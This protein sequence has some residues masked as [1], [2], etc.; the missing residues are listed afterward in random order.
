[1]SSFVLVLHGH[2]PWVVH[3]GR[4][5][6][7]EEWLHEAVAET[8]LPLLSALGRLDGA[9]API[10]VGLTPVLLEQLA[11][12]RFQDAFVRWLQSRRERALRDQREFEGWGDQHLAS[13]AGRHVRSLEATGRHFEALGRDLCGAFAALWQRGRVEIMGSAATHA[14]L[15]LLREDDS[16]RRQI[17]QG[18]ATSERLLGR[19]PTGF[20]MP[21]C[22]YRPEGLWR[23]RVLSGEP[24]HRLGLD[25]LLAEAGVRWTVVD[26][27]LLQGGRSTGVLQ[28]GQVVPVGWDQAGREPERAWRSPLEPH[29]VRSEASS[30]GVDALV[31]HPQVSEQV[32]SSKVGYP[33]DGRYLEFHKRHGEGGL[34]YWRVSS[35]RAALH[36]KARY[37]PD[38]VA[39]TIHSHA[40]HFCAVVRG[41]LAAHQQD[42]GR[43]G[44]LVAPFDAELFGHWWH[45][46][47]AFLLE[48]LSTLAEDDEVSIQTASQALE[49]RPS[50]KEV[51][52]PDGSWGEGGDHR[53]WTA[54]EQDWMWEVA[55]RAEWRLAELMG[56]ADLNQDARQV[57][58]LAE[59]E[60]LLLQAS[61]WWFA[62]QRGGALD[63]ANKRFCW[64]ASA[65]DRLCDLAWDL[66]CGEPAT[67]A[68]R[69]LL[70]ACRQLD[71][72]PR[73]DPPPR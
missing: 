44:V 38:E 45:E 42:H 22:A 70:E 61:D 19:R 73:A 29:R 68:Q 16:V 58:D 34:R 35:A 64:H 49:T 37:E 50:D 67:P 39:E 32:W 21:E 55:H 47:P 60:L 13:L 65:F 2:L 66:Q 26:A 48:V 52:L 71:S 9:H 43:A 31:R 14:Y 23:H 20:W 11:H 7:G 57:L 59:R 30:P 51:W 36:D 15:P 10:T 54:P 69:A 40:Q 53:V 41:A 3:H 63:Y 18:L 25:R 56:L 8:W 6:H 24:E 1:M 72:A 17:E 62:I 28:G 33:G 12:E 4:W 27:P 46:G 5:P